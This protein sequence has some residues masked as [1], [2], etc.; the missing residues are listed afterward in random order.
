[1]GFPWVLMGVTGFLLGF[2][3]FYRVL[4]GFNGFSL[5]FTGFQ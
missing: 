5:G 3:V 4:M 2:I 1:M